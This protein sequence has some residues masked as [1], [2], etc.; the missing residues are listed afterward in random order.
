MKS[1]EGICHIRFGRSRPSSLRS[2]FLGLSDSRSS[3]PSG[4]SLD[5]PS[6]DVAGGEYGL[7]APSGPSTLEKINSGNPG[8]PQ[9]LLG[10][11]PL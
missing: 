1:G 7:K 10:I 11:R 2:W 4:T 3:K 5:W 9:F 8:W 6:P